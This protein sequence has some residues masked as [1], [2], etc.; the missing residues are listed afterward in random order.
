MH[1]EYAMD[2]DLYLNVDVKMEDAQTLRLVILT[3]MQPVK[4]EPVVTLVD[5]PTQGHVIIMTLLFVMMVLA[6]R[7]AQ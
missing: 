6:F 3:L 5:A 4:M 1:V 2:L 7:I